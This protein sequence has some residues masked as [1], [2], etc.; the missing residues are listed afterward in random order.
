MNAATENEMTE[1]EVG[2]ALRQ[3]ASWYS[4]ET[5][6]GPTLAAQ[7]ID[8]GRRRAVGPPRLPSRIVLLA[9][10]LLV[11]TGFVAL[12]VVDRGADRAP[13]ADLGGGLDQATAVDLCFAIDSPL[14][15][16]QLRSSGSVH[17]FGDPD[18][19]E[20][21]LIVADESV[22]V[23]CGLAQRDDGQWFRVTSVVGTHLPMLQPTASEGVSVIVTVGLQGR[24]HV[25]GQIGPSI[26]GIELE[27]EGVDGRIGERIV[28]RIDDGWWGASF[29]TAAGPGEAF[30]AFRVHWTTTE[31]G[32]GSAVGQDLLPNDPWV[33]CA[34]DADCRRGRLVELRE[35]SKGSGEQAGILDDGIV[36]DVEYRS[37]LRGWGECIAESTGTEVAFEDSGLFTVHGS[38][39]A[40]DDAFDRCR[41]THI[42]Y[43][44]EA[45]GLIGTTKN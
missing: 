9:A 14:P 5:A 6:T 36:T 33:L 7:P 23:A 44:I 32:V 15:L 25:A 13:S 41:E 43:V 37:A 19:R 39:A 24:V 3:I 8:H 28:G 20:L 30:P 4:P 12:L 45:V 29:D 27:P 38:G 31:G 1:R 21:P 22:H 42:G 18:D 17:L 34:S 2:D 26:D 16:D 10:S 35:L 11:A 40:I